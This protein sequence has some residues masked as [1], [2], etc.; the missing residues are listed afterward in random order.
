MFQ[1]RPMRIVKALLIV[2]GLSVLHF[3]AGFAAFAT[4]LELVWNRFD[5]DEGPSFLE[6]TCELAADV[7]W[8]PW[9]QL[10]SALN[11]QGGVLEWILLISNS[12][13]WGLLLYGMWRVSA[14]YFKRP[15]RYGLR[16]LFI[17]TTVM[18]IALGAVA[19]LVRR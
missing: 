2:I 6:K 14:P 1:T 9:I 15:Y 3:V 11:I 19:F 7:L 5:S 4:A 12:L 17:V 18:A 16:S 13:L 8:F 10:A